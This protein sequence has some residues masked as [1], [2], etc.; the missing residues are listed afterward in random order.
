MKALN[1]KMST[2]TRSHIVAIRRDG[3]I[4]GHQLRIN[5]GGAG[6][7]KFF[8]GG[9]YGSP[10]KAR[11]AA[12]RAAKEMGL[13]VGKTVGGSQLGRVVSG[14]TT[15]VAG[16]RFEWT[17]YP[18]GAVLSVV[19]SWRDKQGV[20]RNTRYSTH[21][22][23]LDGALDMAIA[24]R[25]SNGAPMPDRAALLKLLRREYRTQEF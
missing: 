10:E 22:H 19:A 15:R 21:K 2:T 16:I 1:L 7:S 4:E 25:T 3:V 5:G 17:P 24:A 13:K 6:L 18:N 23:G 9:K 14:S 11:R 8:A 12:E 20:A